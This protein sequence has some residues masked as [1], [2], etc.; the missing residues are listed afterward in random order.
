MAGLLVRLG[1]SDGRVQ[2][3][4]LSDRVAPY[5]QALT[6]A[7]ND[8]RAQATAL[9]AGAGQRLGPIQTIRSNDYMQRGLSLAREPGINVYSP[10]APPPPVEI[11][12]SARPVETNAQVTVEFSLLP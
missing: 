3:F 9:A 5:Q 6:R 10:P 8:A 12:L 11:E 4:E 2:S 1:A 7:L